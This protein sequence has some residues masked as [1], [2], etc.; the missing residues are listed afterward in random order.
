[1]KGVH[2]LLKRFPRA[3]TPVRGQKVFVDFDKDAGSK[4]IA[5]RRSFDAN[6]NPVIVMECVKLGRVIDIPMDQYLT[7]FRAR[8][9]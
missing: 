7:K 3:V 6:G 5:R 9:L 2:D 4:F 1:M 8:S